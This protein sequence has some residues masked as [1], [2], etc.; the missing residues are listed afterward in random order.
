MPDLGAAY[1]P[2]ADALYVTIQVGRVITTMAVTDA[3]NVDL[4]E[5]HNVIGVEVLGV[6]GQRAPDETKAW[7]VAAARDLRATYLQ[8]MRSGNAVDGIDA[9]SDVG[10]VAD[11]L[12]RRV[13]INPEAEEGATA[14]TVSGRPCTCGHEFS[15]TSAW[16]L[17]GCEFLAAFTVEPEYEVRKYGHTQPLAE[18]VCEVCGEPIWYNLA[19]PYARH[20]EPQEHCKAPYPATPSKDAP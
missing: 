20:V 3:V 11:W 14:E 1:D 19:I 10:D 9:Y 13:G 6:T 2:E 15:K 17:P 4:D 7:V 5:D 12:E 16:H 8:A 18:G